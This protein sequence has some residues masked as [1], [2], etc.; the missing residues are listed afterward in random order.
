MKICQWKDGIPALMPLFLLA[1]PEEQAIYKYIEQCDI[2]AGLNAAVPI[3]AAAVLPLDEESCELKNL[4]ID[5]AFQHK[6]YGRQLV[7]YLFTRYKDKFAFMQVGTS[8]A[9]RDTIRFYTRCGFQYAYRI[10]NFFIDNY[11]NPVY[12][13]GIQCVDMV[14]LNRSLK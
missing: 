9:T 7:E 10:K 12:D 3:G 6:G 1:D 14:V 11:Q 2:F 5:P 8:D 13:S 4:A